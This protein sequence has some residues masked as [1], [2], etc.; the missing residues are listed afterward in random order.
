[1]DARDYIR[2]IVEP[3]IADFDANPTSVRHAF[4]ACVAIFHCVDYMS[5]GQ[6]NAKLREKFRRECP[7]FAQIDRI[8]N[9]FKHG[10]TGHK[11]SK[12]IKPLRTEDVIQRPPAY[13]DV[14]VWDL[15]RWDDV[16][17]GVTDRSDVR[18]DVRAE[19]RS[20]LAYLRGQLTFS[21]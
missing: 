4:Q 20:A 7:A 6:S 1:M 21:D 19:V 5:A 11:Q 17:G 18:I 15:S 14:G 8:A 12:I 16:T 3:T 13:W 10:Q 9:A 2:D